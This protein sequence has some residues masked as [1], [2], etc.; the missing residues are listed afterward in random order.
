VGRFDQLIL[1]KTADFNEGVVA[2]GNDAARIGGGD[3]PLLRRE[4]P[5]AL[6]DGLVISHELFDPGRLSRV[7]GSMRQK[8]SFCELLHILNVVKTLTGRTSDR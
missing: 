3:Q 1:G 2:I 6:S 4:G 5:F 7:I 8:L